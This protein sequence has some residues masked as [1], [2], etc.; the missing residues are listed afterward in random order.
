M[1]T[2]FPHPYHPCKAGGDLSQAFKQSRCLAKA[3]SLARLFSAGLDG[4]P[5]F[6]AFVAIM[7]IPGSSGIVKLWP[8]CNRLDDDIQ[9]RSKSAPVFQQPRLDPLLPCDPMQIGSASGI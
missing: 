7:E 8:C 6:Q 5:E 9:V 1:I 4:F 2:L 3:L